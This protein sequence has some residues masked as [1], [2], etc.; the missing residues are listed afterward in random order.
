MDTNEELQN[1]SNAIAP[2]VSKQSLQTAYNDVFRKSAN[3]PGFYVW[4]F[5]NKIDST[6]FR[7]N[8]V[9]IKNELS[10]LC[11]LHLNKQLNFQSIGRFNHQHSSRPHRDTA[12]PH[13]FLMLGYEP[14]KVNN[15]VYVTDYSKYID[16]QQIS[17]KEFFGGDPDA[18]LILD[19]S[20]LEPF[21]TELNPFPKENYRLLL[22]NNSK[23]FE[24]ATF[25][26]FH[27][28]EIIEKLEGENRVLNYNMMHLC[29][30]NTEEEYNLQA[31]NDFVQTD[32]IDG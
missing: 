11:E 16:S 14:T 18:N 13:S 1:G 3:E 27:S 31:I 17:L 26:V 6:T 5:G 9:D 10:K 7:Q 25:G 24:D 12:K 21:I 20:V 32:Q 2:T 30:L 4:N 8:M 29:N 28:A 19:N 23:S 15:K 22:L